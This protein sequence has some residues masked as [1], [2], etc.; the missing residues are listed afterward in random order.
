VPT[1]DSSAKVAEDET[2][3]RGRDTPWCSVVITTKKRQAVMMKG[4][5]KRMK[6]K[7]M[8][9]VRVDHFSARSLR[10]TQGYC[11]AEKSIVGVDG[12]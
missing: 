1:R 7:N 5:G 11:E 9:A 3:R 10:D 6:I 4:R 2:K 8:P 12:A